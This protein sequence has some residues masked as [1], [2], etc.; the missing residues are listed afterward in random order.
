LVG[1]DT[2]RTRITGDDL[3][4]IDVAEIKVD[5]TE[6]ERDSGSAVMKSGFTAVSVFKAGRGARGLG[7]AG[8]WIFGIT[9]C[10]LVEELAHLAP[11]HFGR[12]RVVIIELSER[13]LRE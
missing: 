9:F 3:A 12:R 1:A 5:R 4:E 8:T 2:G 6:V 11:L 13:F 10:E 7:R